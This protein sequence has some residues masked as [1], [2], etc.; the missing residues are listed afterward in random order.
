MSDLEHSI[1]RLTAWQRDYGDKCSPIFNSDL[2]AVLEACRATPD[3]LHSLKRLAALLNRPTMEAYDWLGEQFEKETGYLIPGK[4]STLHSRE[5]R[6]A[7]WSEWIAKNLSDAA[8]AIA[9][10]QPEEAKG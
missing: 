8:A 7:A 5:T 1:S 2:K 9:K 10:A 3:L 6:V 4:D